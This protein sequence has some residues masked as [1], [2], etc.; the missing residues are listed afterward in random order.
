MRTNR[1]PDSPV[2][3]VDDVALAGRLRRSDAEAS[4]AFVRQHAG[5]ALAVARRLLRSETDAAD[6]VQDAFAS[7]FASLGGYRGEAKL[8]TWLHR[9][10]VNAALAGR[11]A[12]SR[13]H[14]HAIDGLLPSYEADGHRRDVRRAW[15]PA[16]AGCVERE[17]TRAIVRRR[18]DEL[19]DDY[20]DVIALRDVEELDTAETALLLGVTEGAVK[21]R[22]HRARQALRSLLEREF[23]P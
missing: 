10:V 14:E 6:A 21:I 22:L 5:R 18:I 11:R 3:S 19:P 7:F 2:E 1:D 16:G 13:R 12:A 9:I 15:S 8:S 4:E 23:A 17:E 20:R